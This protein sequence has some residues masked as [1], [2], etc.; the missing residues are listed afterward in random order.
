MTFTPVSNQL[1]P[2]LSQLHPLIQPT[3][4][5]WCVPDPAHGRE[6][7][8]K[9]IKTAREEFQQTGH[10]H[11]IP[12]LEARK[13]FLPSALLL[14][15]LGLAEIP[16][17][18]GAVTLQEIPHSGPAGSWEGPWEQGRL[19]PGGERW[20]KPSEAAQCSDCPGAAPGAGQSWHQHT[21]LCKNPEPAGL[22]EAPAAPRDCGAPGREGLTSAR[23]R[24]FPCAV[25]PWL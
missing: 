1:P 5:C 21:G 15:H 2:S 4:M 17:E 22:P 10:G 8:A 7:T 20:L 23:G 14:A 16:C 13:D 3:G 12:V 6:G 19:S 18:K 25:H 24:E 11:V 9:G